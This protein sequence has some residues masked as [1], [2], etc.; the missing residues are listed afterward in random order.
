MK[1]NPQLKYTQL[2]QLKKILWERLGKTSNFSMAM[3]HAD[4]L[5]GLA[6]VILCISFHDKDS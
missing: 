1:E 6:T 2:E 3:I 4:C 5:V